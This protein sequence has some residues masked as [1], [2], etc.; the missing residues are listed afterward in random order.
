M[1]V[2]LVDSILLTVEIEAWLLVDEERR[3]EFRM[4]EVEVEGRGGRRINE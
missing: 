3:K 4:K 2:C 1:I